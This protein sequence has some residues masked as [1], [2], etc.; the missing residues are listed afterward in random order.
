MSFQTVRGESWKDAVTDILKETPFGD[1]FK[2]SSDSV[3]QGIKGALNMAGGEASL[4]SSMVS[5]LIDFIV[6]KAV[7]SFGKPTPVQEDFEDLY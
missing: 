1:A 6:D 2:L 5:Q 3:K 4:S 7:D